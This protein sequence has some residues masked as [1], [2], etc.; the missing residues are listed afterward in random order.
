MDKLDKLPELVKKGILKF[1]E[2]I[3]VEK[4]SDQWRAIQAA[5]TMIVAP[6]SF[7]DKVRKRDS[8]KGQDDRPI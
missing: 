2:E 8:L 1:L 5:I 4:Y 3:P 6:N 7:K